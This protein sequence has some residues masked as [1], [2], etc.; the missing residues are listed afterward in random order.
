MKNLYRNVIFFCAI[1]A[2]TTHHSVAGKK[3]DVAKRVHA[4][5]EAMAKEDANA[6]TA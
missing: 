4:K 1:V 5:L 6:V 2:L 3:D